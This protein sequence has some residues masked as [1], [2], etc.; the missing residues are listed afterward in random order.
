MK[1][2]KKRNRTGKGKESHEEGSSWKKKKKKKGKRKER[3]MVNI[4]PPPQ[5]SNKIEQSAEHICGIVTGHKARSRVES[6]EPAI[7]SASRK[8]ELKEHSSCSGPCRADG[9]KEG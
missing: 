8:H 4:S 5:S 9:G 7:Q 2:G 6:M 3:K 1:G